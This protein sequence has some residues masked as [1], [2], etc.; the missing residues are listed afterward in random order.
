MQQRW[1]AQLWIVR[2]GESAGNVARDAAHVA[3]SARIEIEARD[4]DVPLSDLGRE[5]ADALGRWVAAMPD[6]GRPDVVLTSPYVRA[7]QPAD[8]VRQAGGL[9]DGC[10]DFV[11]DER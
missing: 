5:Q 6:S 2:H 4:V 3:N 7:R 9:A 10:L 8:A 1:P 11:V